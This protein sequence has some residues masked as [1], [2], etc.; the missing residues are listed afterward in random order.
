M[1]S[2]DARGLRSVRAW[3]SD[4][5]NVRS[6]HLNDARLQCALYIKL[7]EVIESLLEI[8]YLVVTFTSDLGMQR[9]NMPS[10]HGCAM[11]TPYSILSPQTPLFLLALRFRIAQL[12]DE[13]LDD[14]IWHIVHTVL[15]S[16][17]HTNSHELPVR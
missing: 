16:W 9:T 13:H 4:L 6:G 17:A 12:P 11:P 1:R 3:S 15:E 8:V 14:A 5:K 2:F 7:V 10:S